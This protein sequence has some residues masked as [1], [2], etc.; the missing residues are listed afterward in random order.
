MK[1]LCGWHLRIWMPAAS[2]RTAR[3]CKIFP[4][5]VVTSL[6]ADAIPVK[7]YEV[8]VARF[9]GKAEGLKSPVE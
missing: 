9:T 7:S 4:P 3:V 2:N 5:N 8:L 1:V 6:A